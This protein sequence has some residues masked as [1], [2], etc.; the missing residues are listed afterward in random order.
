MRV[1]AEL[2]VRYVLEG[3][4]RKAGNRI[5][6]TAQLIDAATGLHVW[7]ERYDRELRDIFY[8]QDEITRTIVGR[9]EPEISTAERDRAMS[10]AVSRRAEH[11]GAWECY[12]RGLW[13][14]WDYGRAEYNKALN[15]PIDRGAFQHGRLLLRR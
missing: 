9:V 15:L 13:H 10:Q 5:R 14:M 4:V 3:G 12:Q 11:L 1:A 7:A 6:V 8:L 2:G